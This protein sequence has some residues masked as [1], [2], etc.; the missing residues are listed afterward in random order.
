MNPICLAQVTR[1]TVT[2]QMR[3]R[4]QDKE[5]RQEDNEF[6]FKYVEKKKPWNIQ[7][8]MSGRHLEVPV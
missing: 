7:V 4:I 8:E 6:S 2:T 5:T 1:W 3:L